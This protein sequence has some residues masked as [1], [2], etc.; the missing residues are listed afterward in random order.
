M[1][2]DYR[3]NDQARAKLDEQRVATKLAKHPCWQCGLTL[4]KPLHGPRVGDGGWVCVND[5]GPQALGEL[6]RLWPPGG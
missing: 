4:M 3:T 1:S 6:F 2:M 5:C